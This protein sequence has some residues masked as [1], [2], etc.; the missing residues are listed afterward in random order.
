MTTITQV[1]P[2]ATLP[3][4]VE[5]PE[6]PVGAVVPLKIVNGSGALDAPQQTAPQPPVSRKSQQQRLLDRDFSVFMRRLKTMEDNPPVRQNISSSDK[7]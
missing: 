7:R 4:A 5:S 3:R 1:G 6:R 2:K